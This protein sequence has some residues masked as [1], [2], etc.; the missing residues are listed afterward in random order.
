VPESHAAHEAYDPWAVEPLPFPA[1]EASSRTPWPTELEVPSSVLKLRW[2]AEQKWGWLVKTQYA[3]GRMPHATTGRPG[4][5]VHT[6]ALRFGGH[7]LT[8]R[9]AYAVYRSPVARLAWAWGGVWIWGP[10]LPPFGQC[11]VTELREFLIDGGRVHGRWM[12]DI[13]Q[14]KVEQAQRVKATAAARPKKSTKESGG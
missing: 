7:R 13:R 5:L 10:D 9:Q 12:D 4:A 2:E 14:R 8:G 3:R 6:V 1:P 11:G